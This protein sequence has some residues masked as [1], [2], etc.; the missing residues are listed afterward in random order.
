MY[1]KYR[2]FETF[3]IK[4]IVK[5]ILSQNYMAYQNFLENKTLNT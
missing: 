1:D 5:I 4:S 2:V 3:E